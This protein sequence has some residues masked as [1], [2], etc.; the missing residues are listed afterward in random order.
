MDELYRSMQADY[1]RIRARA[2]E[3]PGTA[4]D[5]GEESWAE[6]L[7][8]WLPATYP[9]VTKGRIINAD[10]DASPQVDVLVL[11]PAYPQHLRNRKLYLADGVI[12]AFECKLTLRGRH[13]PAAAETGAA[14]KRLYRERTGTP[15]SELHR[16]IIYG[17][18]AHSSDYA[19][20]ASNVTFK[21]QNRLKAALLGVIEHPSEMLDVVCV[22]DAG[23]LCLSQDVAIGSGIGE[24]QREILELRMCRVELSV[25]ISARR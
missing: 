15:Y 24:H 21:V 14:V 7:R 17:L 16:P 2:S 1:E 20:T 4:G 3:D 19:G 10:G 18:L 8:S 12:A 5:E 23:I 11:H 22:A 13:I 6:L 9:V 25:R